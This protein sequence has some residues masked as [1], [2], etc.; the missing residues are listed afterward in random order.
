[1]NRT[2]P[3]L[4]SRRFALGFT[5]I[6]LIVVVVILGVLSALALPKLM[7]VSGEA[8]LAALRGVASAAESAMLVN[9][10]GCSATGHATAGLHATKCHSVRYCDD[11]GSL[12]IDPLNA[13]QYNVAHDDL[14]LSNGATGLCTV[15]QVPSGRSA[16]FGG[17]SAGHP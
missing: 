1:M 12:L 15:T 10:G 4:A 17:I 3:A 13:A 14:G 6:E 16:T 9:Y 7:D 8:E 5:M 11:V 2:A